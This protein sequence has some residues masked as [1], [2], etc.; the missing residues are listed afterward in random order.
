[1]KQKQKKSTFNY[2]L[3]MKPEEN[4]LQGNLYYLYYHYCICIACVTTSINICTTD[5]NAWDFEVRVH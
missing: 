5:F 1:M 3:I 2:R 4:F